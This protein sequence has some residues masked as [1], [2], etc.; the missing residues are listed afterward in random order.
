MLHPVLSRLL[1]RR[2]ETRNLDSFKGKNLWRRL[3]IKP[4]IINERGLLL[5]KKNDTEVI[6]KGKNVLMEDNKNIQ[7]K[8][9]NLSGL[10]GEPIV[11][12]G[13][14]PSSKSIPVSN[15]L[16]KELS[17]SGVTEGFKSEIAELGG[18]RS[19]DN[20]N[21]EGNLFKASFA[22]TVIAN[23][24]VEVSHSNLVKVRDCNSGKLG[25]CV[26]GLA[27]NPSRPS[28]SVQHNAWSRKENIKVLNLDFGD[29]LSE[30][31]KSVKLHIQ[32]ELENSRKLLK[33][34]VIKE[35]FAAGTDTIY[36]TIEWILTELITHPS[37]MSKAQ[38]EVRR[39]LGSSQSVTE[40]ALNKMAYLKEV[41]REVLRMHPPIP[42]LVPREAMK[43]SELEGYVIPKGTRVFINV[44]TISSDPMYWE[45]Q[46]EF[47]PDRFLNSNTVDFKGQN[48]EFT[49]FG[50]GR[51]RCP[52]INFSMLTIECVVA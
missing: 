28:T 45:K 15:N 10:R 50:S 9:R 44:W 27:T 43:A 51:R 18:F 13:A 20:Y 36:I 40:E 46:E 41:I 1:H 3:E 22:A 52:G 4:L 12:E 32:N 23:N 8:L 35:M 26:E 30:D 47:W 48:F 24:L 37:V 5:A 31:G 38:E 42:T 6:G 33:S 2:L 17:V 16:G 11:Y 29:Y 34:L 21:V 7:I 14:S 49:P 39:V 25:G 19:K